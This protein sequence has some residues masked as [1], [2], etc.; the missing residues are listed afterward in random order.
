MTRKRTP[1]ASKGWVLTHLMQRFL[2]SESKSGVILIACTVF[3]LLLTNSPL[4]ESYLS[5]WHIDIAG[6]SI[7]HLINDGLMAIFFLLVGLEIERE[8]YIGELSNIKA[9]L[10]P[11]FAALG[12]MFCPALIHWLFNQGT[13]T[14]DGAGIPMATDIAFALGVLMLLGKRVP[15][16]L[17]IFL[18]ALAIIDDLG[19]IV[20]ITL[21][22]SKGIAWDY[23]GGAVGIFALLAVFNRLKIYLLWPYL[24]L[25]AAAWYCML[26]SGIHATITGVVLAFLIPFGKGD[27]HSPSYRLEHRL[28]GII[29]YGILPLFALA[30]TALVIPSH[31]TQELMSANSVGIM[32]GLLIGKPVGIVLFTLLAVSLGWSRLPHDLRWSHI[33]GAGILGGIGFTMSMFITLLAFETPDVIVASKIAIMMASVMAAILGLGWLNVV[34]KKPVIYSSVSTDK[35]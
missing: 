18:T 26:H 32:L 5:I 15:V 28:T 24:L 1:M 22:Y 11:L 34:S 17:K 23:L 10:L 29:A 6:F 7:E 27:D 8:I 20:V 35:N 30:N 25:G 21:F 33:I 19:A 4:S 13:A 3:S 9:A 16:S 31:W 2:S 12:G 14:Q